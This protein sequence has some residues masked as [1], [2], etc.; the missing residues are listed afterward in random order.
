M[1]I[2]RRDF[3]KFA[4]ASLGA[5]VLAGCG[6]KS[7]DE[8]QA[9]YGKDGKVI[10][11]VDST[12]QLHLINPSAPEAGGVKATATAEPTKPIA[13]ETPKSWEITGDLFAASGIPQSVDVRNVDVAKGVFKN[14]I[15]KG[16]EAWLA[17]PGKLLVGPDFPQDIINQAGGAI[18]RISP[19][20]QQVFFQ[21]GPSYFNLPEGGFNLGT[22]AGV[23]ITVGDAIIKLNPQEGHNWM[24]VLRGLYADGKQDSDRNIRV[25]FE[26]Y[27]AGHI[28]VMRYP[29]KPNGGFISEKQF[30]QIAETS[31]QEETNC[32]AEG[33]SRLSVFFYDANT[34]A[35]AIITQEGLNNHWKSVWANFNIQK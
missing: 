8:L 6:G 24:F 4:G 13:T 29:G 19:V 9:V 7:N 15:G 3:L 27:V 20:N 10:G 26:D 21:E 2:T 25:K 16:T 30:E 17:E 18:E 12:N 23:K 22:T 33:C 32:G 34:G 5:A 11:Y 14:T 35:T 1:E 31:H 28:Q